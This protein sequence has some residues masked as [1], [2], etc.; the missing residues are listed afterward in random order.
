[1][2][3]RIPEDALLE[4]REPDSVI[5]Q[6]EG[7]VCLKVYDS[8]HAFWIIADAQMWRQIVGNMQWWLEHR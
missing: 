1:M 4:I 6:E 2:T 3:L 5:D 7:R 8:E